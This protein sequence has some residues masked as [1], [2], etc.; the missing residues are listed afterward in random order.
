MLAYANAI[1][2][3]HDLPAFSDRLHTMILILGAI[4]VA[5]PVPLRW[6]D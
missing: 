3:S 1:A 2:D 6:P 4:A 5:G